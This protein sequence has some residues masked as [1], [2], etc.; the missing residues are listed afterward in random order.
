MDAGFIP[1]K[2][3]RTATSLPSYLHG[4]NDRGV[5]EPGKRTELL[6]LNQNPLVNISNSRD[7]AKIWVGGIEYPN[8]ASA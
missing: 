5:I 6:L 4:L 7:I 2:A 1:A 3:L 8:V